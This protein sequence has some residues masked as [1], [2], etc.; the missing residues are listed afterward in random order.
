M[1]PPE[2]YGSTTRRG[3]PAAWPTGAIAIEC[4]TVTPAWIPDAPR[5]PGHE[6]TSPCS[7]PRWSGHVLRRKPASSFSSSAAQ[8][9]PSRAFD[10]SCLV[11]AAPCTTSAM[12][13]PARGPS[14]PSTASSAHRSPP[15]A[16]CS[17]C[18]NGAGIAPDRAMAVL[19]ELPVTSP[20]VK[21]VGALIV[22][23]RHAPLFPIDLVEK[24][25]S[26]HRRSR[27]LGPGRSSDRR[28]RSPAVPR[29]PA[30]RT[31]DSNIS[32]IATCICRTGDAA[33]CSGAAA[34]GEAVRR[35]RPSPQREACKTPERA[36]N[37]VRVVPA[38][39]H[40]APGDASRTGAPAR[41]RDRAIRAPAAGGLRVQRG[42]RIEGLR[43]PMM[44]VVGN[45]S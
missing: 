45:K 33:S 37:P 16:S 1:R 4:S 22:A 26:I 39:V 8:I 15:S 24:G 29:G 2:A 30:G 32:G 21:G 7:T 17:A 19:G 35:P 23:G 40:R 25:L 12:S 27:R 44:P 6:G 43:P 20:A 9:G 28:C 13:G 31:R 41:A 11:W 5:G 34:A 38:G 10:Q 18:C 14:S 3:S 36:A 42:S